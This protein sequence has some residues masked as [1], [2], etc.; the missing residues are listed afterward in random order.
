MASVAESNSDNGRLH[1]MVCGFNSVTKIMNKAFLLLALASLSA[2]V[3][4]APVAANNPAQACA[5]NDP[6]A[7]KLVEQSGMDFDQ[8][9]SVHGEDD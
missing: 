3:A 5:A 2:C 4:V 9:C 7:R 1:R 8:F 6:E